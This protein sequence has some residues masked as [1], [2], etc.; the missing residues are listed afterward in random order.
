[1]NFGNLSI[2]AYFFLLFFDD[3]TMQMFRL[4]KQV[5]FMTEIGFMT[6]GVTGATELYVLTRFILIEANIT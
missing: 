2:S 6:H 5:P 1:M 4:E 3:A